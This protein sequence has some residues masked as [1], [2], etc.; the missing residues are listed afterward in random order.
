MPN[1]MHPNSRRVCFID[2]KERV[3]AM[4]QLAKKRGVTYGKLVREA[5]YAV[6]GY[7]QTDP[8]EA[9]APEPVGQSQQGRSAVTVA[10]PGSP[11]KEEGGSIEA[12]AQFDRSHANAVALYEI[13]NT[14]TLPVFRGDI[15][16]AAI[17]MKCDGVSVIPA[18][19]GK[20]LVAMHGAS[21]VNPRVS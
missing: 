6:Y 19:E 20:W 5:L 21:P 3:K 18:G 1:Q 10:H 13:L 16:G 9:R 17:V 7:G 15:T 4:K 2:S 11:A 14:T 8:I 12:K